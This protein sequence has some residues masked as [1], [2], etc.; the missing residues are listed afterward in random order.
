MEHKNIA[1]VF[2]RGI[3]TEDSSFFGELL[4]IGAKFIEEDKQDRA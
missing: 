3:K 4:S 2:A 1:A